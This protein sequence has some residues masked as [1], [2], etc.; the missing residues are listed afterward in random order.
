MKTQRNDSA[1]HHQRKK[2]LNQCQRTQPFVASEDCRFDEDNQSSD[3]LLPHNEAAAGE[4][5]ARLQAYCAM[6]NKP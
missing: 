2:K 6:H 3:V 1:F 5:P 4:L